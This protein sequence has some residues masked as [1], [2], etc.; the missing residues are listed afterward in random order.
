MTFETLTVCSTTQYGLIARRVCWKL[1]NIRKLKKHLKKYIYYAF[2]DLSELLF[3]I[4]LDVSLIGIS[5]AKNTTFS[6][7]MNY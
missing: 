6:K 2:H 7:N 5:S 4:Y 3:L 1:E